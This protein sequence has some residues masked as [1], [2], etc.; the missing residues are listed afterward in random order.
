MTVVASMRFWCPSKKNPTPTHPLIVGRDTECARNPPNCVA[1]LPSAYPPQ[2]VATHYTAAGPQ[3]PT[4]IGPSKHAVT[5]F[6]KSS[7]R[8]KPTKSSHEGKLYKWVTCLQGHRK[9]FS[10]KVVLDWEKGFVCMTRST[11]QRAPSP[12]VHHATGHTV[13]T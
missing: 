6:W 7:K 10:G 13:G 8:E 9:S 5:Q 11:T 3:P 12:R 1:L 4:L 2:K